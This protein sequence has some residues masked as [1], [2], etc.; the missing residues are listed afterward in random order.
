VLGSN[1]FIGALLTMTTTDKCTECQDK[2]HRD[3]VGA[4][5]QALVEVERERGLG[6]PWPVADRERLAED[7]QVGVAVT[8]QAAGQ[9]RPVDVQLAKLNTLGVQVR[10]DLVGD[11]GLCDVGRVRPTAGTSRVSRSVSTW[12]L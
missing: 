7:L 10:L 4:G 11:L 3:V 12:R 6:K 8:D 9:V 1:T 5:E 2:R